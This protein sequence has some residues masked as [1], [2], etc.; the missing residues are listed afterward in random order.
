MKKYLLLLAALALLL[1]GCNAQI[2]LVTPTP[3]VPTA[4]PTYT[5]Y[6]TYTAVPVPG[7]TDPR[8]SNFSAAATQD[9]G[10]CQYATP[11][12]SGRP[13]IDYPVQ[14]GSVAFVFNSA[15]LTSQSMP[16]NG[17]NVNPNAGFVL[18][19]LRGTYTGDPHSIF[20]SGMQFNK[21]P[22]DQFYVM[23]PSG[24]KYSWFED[25]VNGQG[26]IEI[27][28]GAVPVADDAGPFVLHDDVDGWTVDLSS[29]FAGLQSSG[30]SV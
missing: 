18:F 10:S 28:F 4:V 30:F 24:V 15:F 17:H 5:P 21:A 26:G 9:N 25:G 11:T 13:G 3:V 8:A 29:I 22:Y 16:I 7:C 14:A 2:V 20:N 27:L 6:P 1:S 12:P 23:G 19:V